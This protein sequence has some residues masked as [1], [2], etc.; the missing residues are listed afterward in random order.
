ME[1]I[2]NINEETK[3]VNHGTIKFDTGKKI[4]LS[5]E[6]VKELEDK[7]KDGILTDKIIIPDN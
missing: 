6:E 1:L 7:L 3:E 5:A 4:M 2:I